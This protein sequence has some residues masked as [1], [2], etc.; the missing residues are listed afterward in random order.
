[1]SEY[2]IRREGDDEANGPYNLDQLSS[3]IEA[4]KLDTEAFFYNPDSEEW[5]TISSNQALMDL[6][7]PKKRKLTLRSEEPK[8]PTAEVP[9]AP[10]TA[11]DSVEGNSVESDESENSGDDSAA[12]SGEQ[13]TDSGTKLKTAKSDPEPDAPKPISVKDMLAQAE[14]RD[15]EDAK[16]KTPTEI[17]ASA[18]YTG[19]ISTTVLL[20]LSAACLGYIDFKTIESA[21]V[22]LMVKSPYFI[23]AAIDLMLG[24]V[25][26]LQV[27]LIY[28]LVRFRAALGIGFFTPF[29]YS[30]QEPLLLI[31][32]LLIMVGI[33]FCTAA[34]KKGNSLAFLLVGLA[35]VIGYAYRLFL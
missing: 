3:L 27:T 15:R 23:A 11:S 26:L 17:K 1:M 5:E 13:E 16:G 18:A 28:P 34:I 31:S 10:E 12:S 32:N 24:V 9:A 20:F 2:Y 6:L 8:P 29:Y 33:Y 35:G 7:Y 25:L 19:M 30:T 14:G 21:D 22:M 4:D